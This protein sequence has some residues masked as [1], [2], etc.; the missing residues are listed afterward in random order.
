MV[1][2]GYDDEVSSYQLLLETFS[3]D[4]CEPDDSTNNAHVI[5][6]GERLFHTLYPTGDTD[7]VTFTLT[8]RANILIMTDTPNPLIDRN[9]GDTVMTLYRENG[10]LMF[11]QQNDDGN[12]WYFSAIYRAGLDPGRY[13]VRIAGYDSN[14]VCADYYISLDVFEQQTAVESF[15]SGANGIQMCWYG[16][17]SFTYELQYSSDLI[18]TQS[19]VVATNLE[20]RVGVNCWV[21]DGSTTVPGPDLATQRFYKVIAK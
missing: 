15:L 21:D 7:W 20:G 9:N 11:V 1:K 3:A 16:D 8:N 12:N 13:Y 4:S 2:D 17:A 6:S 5:R 18:N 10:G 19:W 14:T